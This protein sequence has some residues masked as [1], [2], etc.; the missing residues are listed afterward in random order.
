MPPS[1][2][3]ISIIQH[4][5]ISGFSS[6]GPHPSALNQVHHLCRPGPPVRRAAARGSPAPRP[7]RA[8]APGV[9][10]LV[11]READALRVQEDAAASPRPRRPRTSCPRLSAERRGR[12][13]SRGSRRRWDSGSPRSLSPW[14]RSRRGASPGRAAAAARPAP[15]SA[16]SSM[17]VTRNSSVL[18]RWIRSRPL[19]VAAQRERP[20]RVAGALAQLPIGEARMDAIEDDRLVR[21]HERARRRRL[22]EGRAGE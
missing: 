3:A 7:R 11:V 18:K 9:G 4:W 15:S 17:I 6:L 22:A 20:A 5:P 8:S 1:S 21:Q 19:G 12:G 2:F 14:R 10:A 13:R 16:R